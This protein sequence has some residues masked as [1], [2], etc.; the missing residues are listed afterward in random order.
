[1]NLEA[2]TIPEV[3]GLLGGVVGLIGGICGII[4]VIYSRRQT[5]LMEKRVQAD[6]LQDAQYAEWVFNWDSAVSILKK[7]YSRTIQTKPYGPLV[8]AVQIVFSDS[9][10]ERIEFHLGRKG[11]LGRLDPKKLSREDLLNPIIQQVISEVLDAA[12]RFKKEHT[13]WAR[14]IGLLSPGLE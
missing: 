8:R 2:I 5:R 4:S 7:T 13:D 10:R 12:G 11:L 14:E 6:R 3:I 1:M 9:L